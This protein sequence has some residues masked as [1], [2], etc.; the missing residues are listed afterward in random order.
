M[1]LILVRHGESVGNFENRL[2][3]TTD[4]DLTPM[5]H[6]QAKRTADRLHEMGVSIVYTSPLLRA[7]NTARAIGA[8]LGALPIE[9][10][11]VREYDFGEL[12][13]ATYAELR[14][15]FGTPQPGPDGRPPER[16][17]PGEEG[18]ETFFKR[19]TESMWKIVEKHP[20]ESIAVVSHGG[21]IALFCQSV[22]GLPYRRP[23]PFAI[24]NC[25]LNVVNVRDEVQDSIARPRATL[26]ALNDTCHL[27]I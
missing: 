10:A 12:A 3:G 1:R 4:Y 19:V 6:E 27:R 20:S 7:A 26:A 5:G 14:R 15:R 16:V 18:R 25:S 23:M 8:R 22:L 11:D 13:G 24:D 17:Y 21:P 9:L 2:Q